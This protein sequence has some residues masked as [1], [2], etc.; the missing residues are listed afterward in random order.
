[1]DYLVLG[2]YLI[3]G[4][5]FA[6]LVV[7]AVHYGYIAATESLHHRRYVEWLEAATEFVKLTKGTFP[8]ELGEIPEFIME[9]PIA[10]PM[11]SQRQREEWKEEDRQ[12]ELE[13]QKEVEQQ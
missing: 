10:S 12:K 11:N 2:L 8:E 6:A 13:K 5:G 9:S 1:M 4:H 7:G 3:C